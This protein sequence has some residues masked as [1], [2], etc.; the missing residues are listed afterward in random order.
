[1][2]FEILNYVPDEFLLAKSTPTKPSMASLWTVI[3]TGLGMI[4]W[5]QS[6][7]G[8]KCV[9]SADIIIWGRIVI[10]LGRSCDRGEV[11]EVFI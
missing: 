3:P 9:L 4:I 6:L 2:A 5:N 1:M 8:L 7:K 10:E 11:N